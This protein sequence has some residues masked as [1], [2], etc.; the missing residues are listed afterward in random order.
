MLLMWRS[1]LLSAPVLTASTSSFSISSLDGRLAARAPN[2]PPCNFIE[3]TVT[4]MTTQSGALSEFAALI[5]MNF[6]APM[7]E[8]K[9]ASVTTKSAAPNASLSAIIDELP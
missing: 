6:S 1:K 4:F 9:P 5:C 3:R 2:A 7:S 8:P